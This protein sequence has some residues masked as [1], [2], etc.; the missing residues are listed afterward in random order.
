[1]T[2]ST[3]ATTRRSHKL[4]YYRVIGTGGSM[5]QRLALGETTVDR[6]VGQRHTYTI[7][8]F[9]LAKETGW[10]EVVNDGELSSEDYVRYGGR[11]R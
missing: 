1:M 3:T 6:W 7:Y 9:K 2:S 11:G 10:Y 5:K 8:N 4:F